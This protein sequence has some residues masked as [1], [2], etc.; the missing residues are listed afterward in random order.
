MDGEAGEA[1]IALLNS[2]EVGALKV[3]RESGIFA[4]P[5][6]VH[7]V[8]YDGSKVRTHGALT[9]PHSPQGRPVFMQA[10]ASDRGLTFAG[11]WAELIFTHQQEK[12][13]MQEFYAKVNAQVRS[14]GRDPR[15]CAILPS[16]EVIAGTSPAAADDQIGRASCR[17]R[18]GQY[19]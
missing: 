6:K 3:D 9:A 4:D 15:A 12:S 7:Y 18:V 13:L 2:W 14:S 5:S 1:C 11:K 10:G 8:R 16:I 17:E 19:V